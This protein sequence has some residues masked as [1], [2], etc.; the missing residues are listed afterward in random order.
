MRRGRLLCLPGSR[1]SYLYIDVVI[2]TSFLSEPVAW[3]R[4]WFMNACFLYG[5]MEYLLKLG[6]FNDLTYLGFYDSVEILFWRNPLKQTFALDFK[7]C[8]VVLTNQLFRTPNL[9]AVV[10][11]AL[12]YQPPLI[13]INVPVATCRSNFL[14]NVRGYL[15]DLN[16]RTWK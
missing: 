13:S 6:W 11:R 10:D 9:N 5:W 16:I 14:L 3:C 12:A 8:F 1:S 4:H 7:T 2:C 15:G